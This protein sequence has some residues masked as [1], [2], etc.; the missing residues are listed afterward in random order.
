MLCKGALPQS[1]ASSHPVVKTGKC[2]LKTEEPGSFHV[3]IPA[4]GS[5]IPHLSLPLAYGLSLLFQIFM[6]FTMVVT[7]A[8]VEFGQDSEDRPSQKD[9]QLAVSTA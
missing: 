7:Y 1:H 4:S 3:N 2:S 8:S 5:V 6:D 9:L